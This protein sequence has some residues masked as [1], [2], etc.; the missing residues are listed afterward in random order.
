M[1]SGCVYRRGTPVCH[2]SS[3]ARGRPTC[4][5]HWLLFDQPAQGML[6]KKTAMHAVHIVCVVL[7]DPE[8]VVVLVV[9]VLE[10]NCNYYWHRKIGSLSISDCLML[11]F[12]P[13]LHLSIHCMLC[14]A[15]VNAAVHRGLLFTSQF[16]PFFP[17]TPCFYPHSSP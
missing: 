7:T 10:Q 13:V 4:V 1:C 9:Q 8:K 15:S 16:P 14:V 11:F 3:A 6:Q 5:A 2:N 12:H 17:L